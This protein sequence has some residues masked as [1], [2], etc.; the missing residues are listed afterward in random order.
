MLQDDSRNMTANGQLN[1]HAM[2]QSCNVCDGQIN[3]DESIDLNLSHTPGAILKNSGTVNQRFGDEIHVGHDYVDGDKYQT[4]IQ[5]VAQAVVNLN[6]NLLGAERQINLMLTRD[7]ESLSLET[8]IVD[9]QQG[10]ARLPTRS[11]IPKQ[12]L[13]L[14]EGPAQNKSSHLSELMPI[15]FGRHYRIGK[16]FLQTGKQF[17]PEPLLSVVP[18]QIGDRKGS[19]I[20]ED[21]TS[22]N[23]FCVKIES[24]DRLMLITSGQAKYPVVFGVSDTVLTKTIKSDIWTFR[25]YAPNQFVPMGATELNTIFT[26]DTSDVVQVISV[27]VKAHKRIWPRYILVVSQDIENRGKTK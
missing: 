4:F 25:R 18:C 23:F 6:V 15:E 7:G 27:D 5:G 2:Q 17:F 9:L 22:Q 26:F 8:L 1:L 3:M 13:N 19:N 11:V 16:Q 12:H 24:H 20:R 14:K 10:F 21:S